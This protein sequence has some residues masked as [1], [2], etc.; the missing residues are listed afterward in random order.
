VIV[1][2]FMLHCTESDLQV[3]FGIL[4]VWDENWAISLFNNRGVIS[5]VVVGLWIM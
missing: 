2:Y 5:V 4:L 1:E 3:Y